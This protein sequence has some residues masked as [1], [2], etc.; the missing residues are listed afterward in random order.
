MFKG[1]DTFAQVPESTVDP[2]HGTVNAYGEPGF[3]E[4]VSSWVQLCHG[5]DREEAF[6]G[7]SI[8]NGLSF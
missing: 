4:V 5:T 3:V 7:L 6:F 8:M 1:V 2:R